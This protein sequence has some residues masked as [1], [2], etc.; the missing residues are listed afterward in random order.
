MKFGKCPVNSLLGEVF[1]KEKVNKC[2]HACMHAH[3]C[4]YKSIINRIIQKIYIH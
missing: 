2:T 1:L 3:G 4:L